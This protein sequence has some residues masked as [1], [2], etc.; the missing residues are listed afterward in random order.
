[1]AGPQKLL[2]MHLSK[3]AQHLSEIYDTDDC[4]TQIH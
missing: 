3:K 1:M 2:R 4:R